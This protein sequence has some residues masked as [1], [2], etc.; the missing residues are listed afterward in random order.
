VHCFRCW[1]FAGRARFPVRFNASNGRR[2]RFTTDSTSIR[3]ESPS[4]PR[5][6]SIEIPFD[7]ARQRRAETTFLSRRASAWKAK[8]TTAAVIEQCNTLVVRTSNGVDLVFNFLLPRPATNRLRFHVIRTRCALR[9]TGFIIVFVA[10]LF[11]LPLRRHRNDR[12][13]DEKYR[14]VLVR[15]AAFNGCG[16]NGHS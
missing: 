3:S 5:I 16:D 14:C 12:V 10:T 8:T 15:R 1:L 4:H 6:P 9:N 11:F 2:E 7:C 13:T